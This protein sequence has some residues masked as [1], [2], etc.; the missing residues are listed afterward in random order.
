MG[1][2]KQRMKKVLR[3][4]VAFAVGLLC[5][6]NHFN[7]Y[8]YENFDLAMELASSAPADPPVFLSAAPPADLPPYVVYAQVRGDF[9]GGGEEW[10]MRQIAGEVGV[11]EYAPDFLLFSPRGSAYA[12]E[13][14]QHV[15]FGLFASSPVYR[16]QATAWCCRLAPAAVGI[17]F[18]ANQMVTVIDEVAR[19]SGMQEGDTLVSLGGV[20]VKPPTPERLSAW[21]TQRLKVRPGD[22]VKAIWIRPGVG[23]K[24]GLLKATAPPAMSKAPSLVKPKPPAE[25]Y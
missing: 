25:Y 2:Y 5:G 11:R 1:R 17:Q 8:K 10:Q 16:P 22:D 3:A 20:A 14:S 9:H 24:E 23:R 15:G 18:D 12:G 4:I 13:V 6:C 7:G 21:D 19:A